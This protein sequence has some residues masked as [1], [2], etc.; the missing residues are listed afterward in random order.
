[1]WVLR[2]GKPVRVP[3]STDVTDGTWSEM[4]Q[5]HLQAGD[6]LITDMTLNR[7]SNLF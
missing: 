4:V 7:Q 3:V 2:D 6:V 1:V 5:G